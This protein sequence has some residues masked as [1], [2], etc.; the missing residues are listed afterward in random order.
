MISLGI[1]AFIWYASKNPGKMLIYI[2]ALVAVLFVGFL[3]VKLLQKRHFEKVLSRLKNA[4]QESFLI[5]FINR[6][7]L[8]GMRGPG[9]EFRNHKIESDRV[10]D[11]KK[12]LKENKVT[13]SE[14]D[15]LAL[16]RFY[17]EEKEEMVTR[18]SIKVEPQLFSRLSGTD[19]EN[20]LRRL[21]E[22]MGYQVEQTGR[23][24]DQGGD[25]IANKN[26]ERILIQAKCYRDLSVGN[27]AVQQVVGAM[28]YYN[29][30]KSMVIT[31]S[32]VFTPEARSLAQV[33]DTELISKDRLSELLIQYLHESW[34]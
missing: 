1:I 33:N 26:G 31:T 14:K 5:N 4:G 20:L 15:V 28:K 12:I 16:L 18:E 11:L 19:F 23:S 25:L 13:S 6:F 21:F 30:G 34:G 3:V 7:A 22:A 27:S 2:A 8:Q 17:I 9:Y 32:G 10:N 24:G 29:C